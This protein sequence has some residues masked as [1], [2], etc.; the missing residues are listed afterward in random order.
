MSSVF[1]AE[2]KGPRGQLT[3]LLVSAAAA[4]T[5][6]GLCQ[7]GLAA[8]SQIGGRGT[9]SR[10][11]VRCNGIRRWARIAGAQGVKAA[12]STSQIKGKLDPPRALEDTLD[13]SGAR[14][15]RD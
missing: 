15:R 14:R 1:R 12:G 7:D 5:G 3:G 13:S 10:F 11:S 6:G 9:L 2:T 8:L 4:P